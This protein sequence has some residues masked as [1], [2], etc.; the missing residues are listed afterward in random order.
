MHSATVQRKQTVLKSWPHVFHYHRSRQN[1]TTEPYSTLAHSHKF[2]CAPFS[3]YLMLCG[4]LALFFRSWAAKQTQHSQE[5]CFEQILRQFTLF[6]TTSEFPFLT[7]TTSSI[8][9]LW[10]LA[11]THTMDKNKQ[12]MTRCIWQTTW[13]FSAWQQTRQKKSELPAAHISHS[14]TILC[15]AKK[16]KKKSS[17]G[18]ISVQKCA[19]SK[20]T[21]SW[22]AN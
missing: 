18:K 9:L 14:L 1:L 21:L 20:N 2:F 16:K 17:A 4:K 3:V 10:A 22:P 7:Q 11:H 13:V 19:L 12:Q 6:E 15:T 8:L 5:C